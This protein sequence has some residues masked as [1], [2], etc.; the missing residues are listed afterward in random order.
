[1]LSYLELAEE[2]VE[3]AKREAIESGERAL[4]RSHLERTEDGDGFSLRRRLA[5]AMILLGARLDPDA[6]GAVA[7]KGEAAA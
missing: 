5:T 2:R 6:V 4:E 1:M 3:L 7:G